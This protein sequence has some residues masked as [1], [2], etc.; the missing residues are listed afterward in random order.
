MHGHIFCWFQARAGNDYSGELPAVDVPH[1]TNHPSVLGNQGIDT[2][3]LVS[4][5]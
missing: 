1:N 5:A 4:L 3:A 2:A